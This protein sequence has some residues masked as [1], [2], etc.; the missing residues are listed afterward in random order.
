[1]DIGPQGNT[2]ALLRVGKYSLRR[3]KLRLAQRFPD[4][5]DKAGVMGISDQ[6]EVSKMLRTVLI[7]WALSKPELRSG[8][9][10]EKTSSGWSNR[11]SP[12]LQA[13]LRL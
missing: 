2:K 6:M 3:G 4:S 1:M 9:E 5:F 12:W 11:L 10:G 8:K 7:L 13:C